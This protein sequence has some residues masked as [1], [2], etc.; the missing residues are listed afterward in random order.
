MLKR[1]ILV[2]VLVFSIASLAMFTSCGK[3]C[4]FSSIKTTAI[5][6]GVMGKEY[7]YKLEIETSCSP[8]NR[9]ITL[10][11][12]SLPPGITLEASGEFMGTPTQVGSYTFTLDAKVCFSTNGFEYTDCS[13]KSKQFTMVITN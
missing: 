12:G 3:S 2:V 6:D 13:T 8:S 4:S 10:N 11:S 1:L 7:Y 9:S 5:P